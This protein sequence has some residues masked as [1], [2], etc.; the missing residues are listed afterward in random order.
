[1]DSLLRKSRAGVLDPEQFTSMAQVLMCCSNVGLQWQTRNRITVREKNVGLR[2]FLALEQTGG[3]TGTGALRLEKRKI[4]SGRRT[5]K[6]LRAFFSD[7]VSP[8]RK[9]IAA[10]SAKSDILTPL[11][12]ES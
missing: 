10:L 9:C 12:L 11:K 8:T 4:S 3:R 7:C 1:V 6:S 2:N 5:A